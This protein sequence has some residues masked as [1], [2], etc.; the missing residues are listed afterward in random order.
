MK[1]LSIA[2]MKFDPKGRD[3]KPILLDQAN[4]LSDFGFFQRGGMKEMLTFSAR[5]F[6]ER[7]KL[8]Q[9]HVV[10]HEGYECYVHLRGDTLGAV[11]VADVEYPA[12]VAF[13]L[14]RTA[15]EKYDEGIGAIWRSAMKDKPA[16]CAAIPALLKQYQTP[17]HVDKIMKIRKD[18]DETKGILH[19][20]ID[21]LLEEG[22]R[23]EELV[24]RSDDLSNRSKVF[25]KDTKKLNKCC[26]IM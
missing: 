21:Q 16:S 24:E 20:T 11:V 12:R 1:I 6:I 18:L 10:T 5:T 7:T 13:N 26:V 8:G 15:I 17:E 25:L 23:L 19:Q 4:D 2:V 14:A 22:V 3:P 9:R